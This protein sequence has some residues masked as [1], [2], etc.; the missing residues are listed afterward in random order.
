VASIAP[1][2]KG[3]I[4]GVIAAGIFGRVLQRIRLAQAKMKAPDRPQQITLE[5]KQTPRQVIREAQIA[6][7]AFLFWLLI[8][9][10]EIVVLIWG[11]PHWSQ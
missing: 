3:F 4:I 7:C 9:V 6:T 10:G 2:Y 1:F 8:L 5:T 11:L